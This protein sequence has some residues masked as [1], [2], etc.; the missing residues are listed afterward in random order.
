MVDEELAGK[1]INR[2][3]METKFFRKTEEDF[4]K[5]QVQP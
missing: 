2:L 5:P 1:F 3:P 4:L